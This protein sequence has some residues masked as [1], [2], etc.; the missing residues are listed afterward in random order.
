MVVVSSSSTEQSDD[1]FVLSDWSS[2]SWSVDISSG[3]ICRRNDSC[4]SSNDSFPYKFRTVVLSSFS[5]RSHCIL[6][7]LSMQHWTSSDNSI[8]NSFFCFSLG[9]SSGTISCSTVV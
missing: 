1:R 6:L 3:Y 8:A 7:V 4:F 2:L 9:E 5:T